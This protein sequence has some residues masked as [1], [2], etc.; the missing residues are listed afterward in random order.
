MDDRYRQGPK[1]PEY[2][3]KH[4]LGCETDAG[5]DAHKRRQD[6]HPVVGAASDEDESDDEKS[7]NLAGAGDIDE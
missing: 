1:R 5:R 6:G 2:G 4:E 3:Q 7:K